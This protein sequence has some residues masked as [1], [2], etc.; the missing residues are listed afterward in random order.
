MVLIGQDKLADAGIVAEIL[1][2][3]DAPGQDEE[4]TRTWVTRFNAA[5][6]FH[7]G[8]C[9]ILSRLN[10][11]AY[12]RSTQSFLG[13]P[14]TFTNIFRNLAVMSYRDS[15]AQSTDWPE[16]FEDGFIPYGKLAVAVHGTSGNNEEDFSA[17]AVY[18]FT[19]N[20]YRLYVVKQTVSDNALVFKA[21]E[22]LSQFTQAQLS[23][24]QN[25]TGNTYFYGAMSK[26]TMTNTSAN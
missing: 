19:G 13:N 23:I 11:S 12:E 16:V 24:G 14:E 3:G 2:I 15:S 7:A 1:A 6:G 17:L 18:G 25:Q 21:N 8:C 20:D 4:D 9:V 26:P 22:V 5:S 10:G